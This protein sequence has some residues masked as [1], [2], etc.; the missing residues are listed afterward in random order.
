[1]P[2][3]NSM[4]G[5]IAKMRECSSIHDLAI[6]IN[7]YPELLISQY[8]YNAILR[9][10]SRVIKL[11]HEPISVEFVTYIIKIYRARQLDMYDEAFIRECLDEGHNLGTAHGDWCLGVLQYYCYALAAQCGTAM[12]DGLEEGYRKYADDK[13]M[14]GVWEYMGWL[15]LIAPYKN[16]TT[17]YNQV[18][19]NTLWRNRDALVGF[20]RVFSD[21]TTPLINRD[22]ACE[23]LASIWCD[24]I[25]PFKDSAYHSDIVSGEMADE[26][27]SPQIIHDLMECRVERLPAYMG[28]Y[29][30]HAIE[31]VTDL[32]VNLSNAIRDPFAEGNYFYDYITQI[33]T[34]YPLE[35]QRREIIEKF[36]P[37]FHEDT[38]LI[39]TDLWSSV[40][41][42]FGTV[43][44]YQTTPILN[45]AT[46]RVLRNAEA[47]LMR[48]HQKYPDVHPDVVILFFNQICK[49]FGR[50]FRGA[51]EGLMCNIEPMIRSIWNVKV[52][53]EE[54]LPTMDLLCALEGSYGDPE[55]ISNDT[56]TNNGSTGSQ[57]Q[58]TTSNDDTPNTTT[59]K[60]SLH[61]R[62]SDDQSMMQVGE[63]KIYNAY[64]KYKAN[65][66]KVDSA[67][68]KGIATI[69]RVITGDQQAVIIEGKQF[70]PIGFLKKAIVT[71]GIFNYSKIAGILALIVQHVLKKKANDSE[72]KKLL[73]ELERELVMINEKLE[74]A[75]GDGNREAK[76]DLMRT[77]MAYEEAIRRIR[78]GIGAEGVK[79]GISRS[80]QNRIDQTRSPAGYRG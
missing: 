34:L 55:D 26:N 75:R 23:V 33:S 50:G 56:S 28:E 53:Q 41:S 7:D 57:R 13:A 19:R 62:A 80:S 37:F 61:R 24:N 72:K 17:Q 63:R 46:N 30:T 14:P 32:F 70:S 39:A 38:W 22:Q 67:L 71:V 74:D 48:L 42:A 18:M 2:T 3:I 25:V 60:R 43:N 31:D 64:K 69:K 79:T 36:E 1:M 47:H 12:F 8:G 5:K 10:L 58:R 45:G 52:A 20:L 49:A 59:T 51:S 68:Q 77:K 29:N 6:V 76:Y 16:P 44:S 4:D 65:E 54:M 21:I 78:T 15:F 66:E 40:V 73:G 9:E 27:Y 35:Q 11:R